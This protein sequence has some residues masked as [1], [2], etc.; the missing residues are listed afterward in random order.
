MVHASSLKHSD[1]S[2]ITPSQISSKKV[3]SNVAN[4]SKTR[5]FYVLYSDKTWV[6]DQ[7][8]RAQGPI[9]T[10]ILFIIGVL[11]QNTTLVITIH[12]AYDQ[13]TTRLAVTGRV[14]RSCQLLN[15]PLCTSSTGQRTFYYR[16]VHI[17]NN[18]DSTF[19]TAKIDFYF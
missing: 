9:Y 1:A 12:D 18:L 17:W 4:N 2:Q 3:F 13:F 10:I 15:I 5:F 7:L 16:M 11:L 19:K 6:F 8:E 14:T